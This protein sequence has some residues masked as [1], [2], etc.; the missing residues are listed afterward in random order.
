MAAEIKENLVSMEFVVNCS[1]FY[2]ISMILSIDS[3][4]YDWFFEARILL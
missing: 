4:D 3:G 1:S 2:Q